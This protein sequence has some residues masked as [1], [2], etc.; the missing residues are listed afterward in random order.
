V[1]VAAG[2][3]NGDGRIDLF[4]TSEE[5]KGIWYFLGP[6]DP[7]RQPWTK[8]T[9]DADR[10]HNHTCQL[11]DFD[12]DGDLDF[13]TAQMH[14]SDEDRVT[15]FENTD[16]TGRNWTEHII[17]RTGS[18]NAIIADID[19]DGWLDVVGKNW[20]QTNPIQI[21]YNTLSMR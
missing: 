13:L 2:D 14:Q 15:I 19:G 6:E 21:W 20:S 16:G 3:V 9:L 1:K 10:T 11:A 18:H 8:F 5:G 17:G 7:T 12:R 4:H